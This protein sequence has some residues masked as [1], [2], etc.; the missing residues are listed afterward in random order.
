MALTEAPLAKPA[1]AQ[2]ITEYGLSQG[3]AAVLKCMLSRKDKLQNYW[4]ARQELEALIKHEERSYSIV[5]GE[6]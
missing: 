4:R 1:M 2:L 5:C 6:G 3:E